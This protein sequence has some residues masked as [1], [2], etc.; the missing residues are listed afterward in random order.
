[1]WVTELDQTILLDWDWNEAIVEQTEGDDDSGFVFE[2]YN[3]YQLPS[4]EAT[5]DQGERL[6]TFDVENGVK[7]ILGRDFDDRS[8]LVVDVPLQVGSD[9]GVRRSVRLTQDVLRGGPLVNGQE[10]Y[11]AVTAYN[12]NA[13]EDAAETTLESTPQT[14]ICVPQMPPLGT[15][16]QK[17]INAEHVSGSSDGSVVVTVVN[18]TRTPGDE[19]QVEFVE[20]EVDDSTGETATAWQLRNTTRDEIVVEAR[21]DQSGLVLDVPSEYFEIQV[22]EAPPGMKAWDIPS[23]ERW[24]SW[25]GGEWDA[26]GFQGA[27]TGDPNHQWFAPTTVTPDRLRTVEL[28]F[29]DVIEEDGEDQYKPVD[30]NNE[31]V[32]WAYRYLRGAGGDPPAPDSLTTTQNPWDFGKY[33]IN[34]EGP[35]VYV[36]Q[37]RNPI[38][39]SA[40]D[41]ESDPPRRLEVA[42]LENNQPGGL[43]NGVYGPPW[44]NVAS[45]VA[46]SGPRE[47]LFI[48]DLEY[49]DPNQGQ[50]SEILLRNGLIRNAEDQEN[51]PF[52]WIIFAARDKENRFPSDGDSFLLIANQVNTPADRFSFTVEGSVSSDSLFA[53][54]VKRI[55]VFPNPYLGVN[56]AETSRYD[57]FVTF[58]HLPPKANIRIFDMSG[59]LVRMIEKDDPSQF[60]RWDLQNHNALPVASGM[61]IAHIELPNHGKSRILKLAIIQE[62]QFLE[63]F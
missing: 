37:E 1:M 50:N 18:P 21:T 22:S 35:G 32:S 12:Y 61:Y 26:E 45:N 49:T 8:G 25:V 58:S 57:H 39:L 51:L 20:I 48:F 52:M 47:W 17:E 44:Y 24:F 10:Y 55:N 46:S 9:F 42:F 29:T 63:N 56:E 13:A 19:Y 3:L 62:Q 2:G 54:D 59:T 30:V 60:T 33:I 34:T 36:Y 4:A 38:A 43:V 31:N 5:L 6:S 7:T 40:W 15:R 11:F 14:L 28:R 53:E 23:G 16:Y 27:M 41:I